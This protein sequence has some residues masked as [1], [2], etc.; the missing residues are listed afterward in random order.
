MTTSPDTPP[1]GPTGHRPRLSGG[2]VF[3]LV[4]LA[5]GVVGLFVGTQSTH[6]T[7]QERRRTLEDRAI[8]PAARVVPADGV[9]EPGSAPNAVRWAELPATAR[10]PNGGFANALSKMVQPALVTETYPD[11]DGRLEASLAARATRRAYD[12]APPTIPHAIEERSA[13]SCLACHG[14][15]L[16]ING[17]VAPKVSHE[18]YA[19]CTQ[20]HVTMD[21]PMVEMAASP[22]LDSSFVGLRSS[23][24][25]RFLPDAPPTTPHGTFMRGDCASCHGPLGAPGLRTTHPERQSCTQCHATNNPLEQGLGAR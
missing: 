1:T 2:V 3:A 9:R 10:G 5:A 4:V 6:H 14:E 16:V 19:Q 21:K 20:C 13:M 15:G 11:R 25:D 24:G 23:P 18:R 12:G 17:R 7:A 8:T 22:P